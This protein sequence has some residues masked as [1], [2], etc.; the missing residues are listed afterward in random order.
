MGEHMASTAICYEIVYPHLARDAVRQG[1]ELLTTI[2]ND[3]WYGDS[4]APYQHFMQAA[5]RA[6]EN[7]R[8]MVRSANTGVTGIVDPYGRVVAQSE[9]FTQAVI[10][11]DVRYRRE[12]TIYTR[13]G[14]VFAYASVVGVLALVLAARRRVQYRR[15]R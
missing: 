7:G 4:S 10:V 12:S 14:D 3:A 5:M 2:T 8:Y 11:G 9:L 6:I 1:A 15:K 13:T